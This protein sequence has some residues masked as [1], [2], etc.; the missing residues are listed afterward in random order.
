[1]HKLI[2]A[3]MLGMLVTTIATPGASASPRGASDLALRSCGQVRRDVRWLVLDCSPGFA[4]QHD[5]VTFFSP[6]PIDPVKPWPEVLDYT[7]STWLFDVGA[8]GHPQIVINYN[9]SAGH[10]RA[11]VYDAASTV[12]PVYGVQNGLLIIKPTALPVVRVTASDDWWTKDGRI[13]FNLDLTVDGKVMGAFVDPLVFSPQRTDGHPDFQIHVRDT[14]HDGRPDYEWI[15][16]TPLGFSDTAG[17]VHTEVLSD[18]GHNEPP[19]SGYWFWPYL[20]FFRESADATTGETAESPNGDRPW[21]CSVDKGYNAGPPPIQINASV[22]KVQCIKEF[23]ASRWNGNNWFTSSMTSLSGQTLQ[24]ANWEAPFAFYDLAQRDDGY[25]DLQIRVV[26][27]NPEDAAF[28]CPGCPADE[29]TQ[30]V[31]YTWDQNHTHSWTYKLDLVGHH[32]IDTVVRFP[33]LVFRTIPYH[34]LPTWVSGNSWDATAFV[35]VETTQ[36][37]WTSEGVYEW[38][39]PT[40]LWTHYVTGLENKP[41]DD[42]YQS[43]AVG[44]RGEYDLAPRPQ[45][46]LYFSPVDRKLHLEDAQGGVWNLNGS[47]EIRYENLGGNYL[48][49]W[50][51][52]DSGV[53]QAT[54][55]LVSGQ[56]VLADG[57][58]VGIKRV[59]D[60]AARFTVAPPTDHAGWTHLRDLVEQ[61]RPSFAPDDFRAMFGQFAGP[62]QELPGATLWDFRATTDGFRFALG[63]PAAGPVGVPWAARLSAGNYVVSYR[64]QSGYAIQPLKPAALRVEPVTIVGQSPTALQPVVLETTVRNPGNADAENQEIRFTARR[65]GQSARDLGADTVAILANGS[66]RARVTWTP[67]SAGAWLIQ[68]TTTGGA[69]SPPATVEITTPPPDDPVALL[70]LSGPSGGARFIVV[71]ILGAAVVVGGA[72]ATYLWRGVPDARQRPNN[73]E[74]DVA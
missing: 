64:A 58:G 57:N 33:G 13:N 17:Y 11:D 63:L 14:D 30:L 12:E 51:L 39:A 34:Q 59:D 32:V 72:S 41:P 23:V 31:R 21:P 68:A 55:A 6:V 35:A 8:T 74:G 5:Q 40:E 26:N 4:S 28:L 25:P 62:A 24:T 54:L 7:N 45:P 19:L 69:A 53:E 37:Y 56:L 52:V 27:W 71:V 15:D 60:P 36:P 16:V 9:R 2:I 73:P 22:G 44:F 47:R 3:I 20:G 43:I 48:D 50:T 42:F 38:D 46:H 1:M 18:E 49:R 29:N 67:P 66:A 10:L 70:L 61:N 65:A